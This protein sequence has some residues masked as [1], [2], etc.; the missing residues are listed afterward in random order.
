MYGPSLGLAQENK[1]SDIKLIKNRNIT[2]NSID[3][4]DK[5]QLNKSKGKQSESY[6]SKKNNPNE[7]NNKIHQ[8]ILFQQNNTNGIESRNSNKIKTP[9]NPLLTS[10][11]NSNQINNEEENKLGNNFNKFI[12]NKSL[13]NYISPSFDYNIKNNHK[14][15]NI[16]LSIKNNNSIPIKLDDNNFQNSYKTK[17]KNKQT[18]NS[19]STIDVKVSA[20]SLNGIDS[21]M[22][23]MRKS[24]VISRKNPENKKNYNIN[25]NTNYNPEIRKYISFTPGSAKK[26][27]FIK[28]KVSIS[29]DF[30]DQKRKEE[31]KMIFEREFKRKMNT[32]KPKKNKNTNNSS[33]ISKYSR[34]NKTD[35]NKIFRNS[36]SQK[37]I[38][39]KNNAINKNEFRTLNSYK[40][41][42]NTQTSVENKSNISYEQYYLI[43]EQKIRKLNQEITNLKNEEKNLQAQLINYTENEKECNEIRKMREEIEKYKII[44]EKSSKACEEYSAEIQKIKNIIGDDINKNNNGK[45]FNEDTNINNDD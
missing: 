21:L 23:I 3:M 12:S 17:G 20:S 10:K 41:H 8:Y 33:L 31:I 22:D 5:L 29:N 40:S 42:T 35:K 38:N 2:N 25:Y 4:S 36:S 43:L 28:N 13:K 37:N 16:K 9:K 15:N 18:L 7:Y 30:E 11:Q 32:N 6:I 1:Y 26:T 27:N 34:N 45:I 24:N 14:N 19:N 39:K 44:F